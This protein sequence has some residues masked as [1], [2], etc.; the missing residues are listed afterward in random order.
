MKSVQLQYAKAKLSQLVSGL[1]IEG[2]TVITVR[3][4]EAAV[5]VSK[6]E[7]DRRGRA[8]GSLLDFLR[9]SPL[10]GTTMELVRVR[11]LTRKVEL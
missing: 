11:S 7:F 4:R 5:L 2:P 6:R 10:K 8:R 3:G 9:A 1:E